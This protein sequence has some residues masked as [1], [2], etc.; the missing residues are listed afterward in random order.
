MATYTKQQPE[1]RRRPLVGFRQDHGNGLEVS[2]SWQYG[3]ALR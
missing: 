1:A 2:S 3:K